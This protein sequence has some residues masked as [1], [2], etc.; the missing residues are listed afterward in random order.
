MTLLPSM[1]GNVLR[2]KNFFLTNTCQCL[3][4]IYIKSD[5]KALKNNILGQSYSF[6]GLLGFYYNS[7][8]QNCK[9]KKKNPAKIA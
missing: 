3:P 2:R 4:K 9:K 1:I 8:D 6:L 5:T 7:I